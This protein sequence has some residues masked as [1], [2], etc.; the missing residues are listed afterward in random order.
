[1]RLPEFMPG[2]II[3]YKGS[4]VE[5]R[6]SGKNSKGIYLATGSRFLE[7]TEKLDVAIRI[8]NRDD[9]VGAV[10]VAVEGDDIMVLDPTTFQTITL[11][12]PMFFSSKAGEEIPVISTEQGLF[13][14]P[15]DSAH[16]L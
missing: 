11:K 13:A 1:M 12:K 4:V 5:I 2:D 16:S 10:L 7:E 6:N 9:A 3:L 8:A 15:E 14:L